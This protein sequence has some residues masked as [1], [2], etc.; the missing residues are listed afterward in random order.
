MYVCIYIYTHRE[1]RLGPSPLQ[2]SFSIACLSV[3][4]GYLTWICTALAQC[5]MTAALESLH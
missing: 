3:C 5:G 2:G 1:S 4:K